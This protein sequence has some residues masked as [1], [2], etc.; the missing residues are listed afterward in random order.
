MDKLQALLRKGANLMAKDKSEETPMPYAAEKGYYEVVKILLRAGAEACLKMKD[1]HGRTPLDC[2][3]QTKTKGFPEDLEILINFLRD[4]KFR[5]AELSRAAA[6]NTLAT[7]SGQS[8]FSLV[9]LKLLSP[10][11]CLLLTEK[12]D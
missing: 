12:S 3:L 7:A 1:I 2:C 5:Q 6:N 9:L 4:P 8:G 10:E 11:M